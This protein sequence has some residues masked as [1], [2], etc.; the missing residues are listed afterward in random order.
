MKAFLRLTALCIICGAILSVAG[1]GQA[2]RGTTGKDPIPSSVET[3]AASGVFEGKL[4]TNS[5]LG[6]SV[7]VPG[8][9]NIFTAEQNNSALAAGQANTLSN[10][11]R[12]DEKERVDLNRSMANTQILFQATSRV[13]NSEPLLSRISCGVERLAEPIAIEKYVE[14]NK[15]LVLLTSPTKLAK[16]VYS[17]NLSGTAFTGFD[18]EG[19]VNEKVFRQR[20]LV[21]I[22]KGYALF[23]ITTL[24]NNI[25]D[26]VLDA[27]LKTLKFGK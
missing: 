22:R 2:S 18:V 11:W 3:V 15:R 16:D 6:F 7:L 25:N 9:W 8:G 13:T 27:S 21:T 19:A 17:T 14:R 23:I 24:W 20:Y 10:A 12:V 1:R 26:S 4:Y 5:L